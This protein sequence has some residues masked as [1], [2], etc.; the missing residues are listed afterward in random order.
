VGYPDG[1]RN[2]FVLRLAF[3]RGGPVA[4]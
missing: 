4:V 2:M 3:T 1:A